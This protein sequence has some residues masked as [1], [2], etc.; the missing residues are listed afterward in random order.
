MS[1]DQDAGLAFVGIAQFI[2]C[3]YGLGYAL[4]KVCGRRYANAVAAMAA[5]V[6]KAIAL[7]GI[8]AVHHLR[9]HERKRVLACTF[10]PSKNQ[11][12]RKMIAA[13]TLP[14]PPHRR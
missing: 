8:E 1:L 2:A 11:R 9:Q 12:L 13:H 4:F 5:K 3:F 14:Q 7:F 10:R 6:R